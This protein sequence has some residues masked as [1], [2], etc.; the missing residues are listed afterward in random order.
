MAA[1]L[2]LR[3][4]G[5]AQYLHSS[6]V[7]TAARTFTN[8]NLHAANFLKTRSQ[9]LCSAAP[10]PSM[11]R[12]FIGQ[13]EAALASRPVLTKSITSGVLYGA[14]DALAQV[15]AG[16]NKE[17]SD[18]DSAGAEAK[19]MFDA[20]RWLRAVLFGGV[21]YPGLA[22]LHYNF[23]EHLVV[24]RWAVPISRVP[25]AKMFIEQFVYWSYFSN[26]YYHTVL[27]ALQGFSPQQCYDRV[28][29]TLWDTLKAQWMFWIPA[30]LINFSYVPVRHQ[31]NFVLVVSLF[32]TTFLSLAFPPEPKKPEPTA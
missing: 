2:R 24:V 10:Q 26:A 21:F 1:A 4:A 22:H 5:T 6:T 32:W 29:S 28:A 8:V 13:Y 31:L 16:R 18:S 11:M 14:G 19:G 27:G 25:F 9:G 30:Q 3:R 7:A 15:I 17:P 23:L 20:S 12:T